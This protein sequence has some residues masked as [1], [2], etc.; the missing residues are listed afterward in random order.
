MSGIVTRSLDGR[1]HEI[2][3]RAVADC[4]GQHSFLCQKGLTSAKRRTGYENQVAF[5]AQMSDVTRDEAPNEESTHIFY[6]QRH[7]WAWSIPLSDSLTSIGV[8][9]PKGRFN[10]NR[11]PLLRIFEKALKI[12]NPELAKRTATAKI[13]SEVHVTSN[14]SYNIEKFTG[15]GFL[16]VGDSHR[17]LDP[18]FSFGV[19][20]A[21]QEAKLAA[22]CLDRYLSN[23]GDTASDPFSDYADAVDAAQSVVEYVIR[24]FWDY[25]LVFLKLAHISHR[26]DVAEI[27]SGRLYNGAHKDIEAVHIMRDLVTKSALAP[28]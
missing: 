22:H 24:T 21:L 10:R 7:H 23:P 13:A 6:D 19:L 8:V 14:Y 18:I 16:C 11:E 20:I 15:P 27:F 26:D 12:I 2:G 3:A 1:S 5:F 28:A 25:P 9:L 17:F 4:S